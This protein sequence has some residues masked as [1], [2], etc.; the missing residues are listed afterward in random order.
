LSPGPAPAALALARTTSAS[1][2]S[3][4]TGPKVNDRKRCPASTAPSPDE[5]S[6][7]SGR[8]RP[9]DVRR[10]RSGRRPTPR[11]QA[12]RAGPGAGA[13]ARP[14]PLHA[15]RHRHAVQD[16]RGSQQKGASAARADHVFANHDLPL[17]GGTF[18][19]SQVLM[20]PG[21]QP[22]N[23]WIEAYIAEIDLPG[24]SV[25]A[26]AALRG[27]GFERSMTGAVAFSSMAVRAPSGDHRPGVLSRP[28]RRWR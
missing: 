16:V 26:E 18:R 13:R 10:R 24:G 17:Q 2:W 23:R 4:R 9:R 28:G 6:H 19:G 11:A 27:A 14:T 22:I 3:E 12:A 15:R 8:P 20:K 25:G 1:R 21:A 7:H 5:P